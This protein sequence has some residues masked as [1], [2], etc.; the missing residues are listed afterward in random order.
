MG[1]AKYQKADGR[2][3]KI[4]LLPIKDDIFGWLQINRTNLIDEVRQTESFLK[5]IC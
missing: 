2:L 3:I 1:V 5:N 4:L